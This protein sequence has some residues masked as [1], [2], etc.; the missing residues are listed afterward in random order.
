MAERDERA[1]GATN[2]LLLPGEQPPLSHF[3]VTLLRHVVVTGLRYTLYHLGLPLPDR[4]PLRI[5]GLRLYFD[6]GAAGRLLD[7]SPEGRA[8]RGAI[9]DPGGAAGDDERAPVG[10]AFFHRMRLWWGRRRSLPA[11]PAPPGGSVVALEHHFRQQLALY[12][13]ALNDALLDE[14]VTAL[15]RRGRRARGRRPAP[16]LGSAAAAW[17]A[18][19]RPRLDRLGAPDP[20]VASWAEDEPEVARPGCAIARD[21]GRG[22]FRETYRQALEA[23]RPTLRAV[24]EAALANGVVD[25][26]DDLFFL[27]FELLDDLT[28]DTQPAWL[29]AAVLRNR[30][31]YFGLVQSADE[32][33]RARWAA[34]AVEPL[35]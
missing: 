4:A 28:T 10:A 9:V 24:G 20:F 17:S 19:G 35:A 18:G 29:P 26:R 7:G 25:H 11:D 33:T 34:A 21:G 32:A 31:E 27:P 16:A 30:G 3:G 14:V 13:P 5:E 12:L 2:E 1:V 22:R 23:W 6:A 8:V 15:A